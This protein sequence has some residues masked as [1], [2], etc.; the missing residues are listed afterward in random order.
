MLGVQR[1]QFYYHKKQQQRGN[2]ERDA[3]RQRAAE[4]HLMSRG[5]AG[6]RTLSSM[7]KQEGKQV[8]RYKAGRLMKEAGLISHQPGKHRYRVRDKA[9]RIANNEL[10]RCFNVAK[11]NQAWCGDITFIKTAQGWS[12][13][14]VV[15]DLYA[16]KVVGWALSTVADS[17]LAQDALK[18][19]W[20]SRGC[21]S[22]VLFHSDQGTQYSS[23]VYQLACQRYGMRQSMSRRGNCL[24]NAVAERLFRSLKSEWLPDKGYRDVEEAKKDISFYLSGYYNRVRPHQYNGGLSPV[25]K[26]RQ[27]LKNPLTVS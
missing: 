22:D 21:P 27:S 19:A 26:E 10:N 4:L 25:E 12:Y 14:A 24:D 9:S 20:V 2:V 3:L 18:M 7:L 11:P 23:L 13:L 1:S 6:A 5:S 16:R 8:G 15:M 17:R